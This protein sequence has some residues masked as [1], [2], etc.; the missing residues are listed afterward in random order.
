MTFLF[1]RG[2]VTKSVSTTMVSIS[3][4]ALLLVLPP[5][6]AAQD[7]DELAKQ[8]QNPVAEPD[9]RAAPGQLG[10]RPRRQRHHQHAAQLSAGRA[11]RGQLEHERHPARHHAAR[12]RSRGDRGL[13][14][15]GMGDI[16]ATAF[17]S[18]IE[19][20]RII[21]GVGPVVL[22]PT[23]TDNA[24][25]TQ[26]FGMGPTVVV[27]TQP[28]KWTLGTAV[29]PDLVDERRQGP[30]GRQ[31]D[32]P[33]AVCQLQ[34]GKRARGGRQHGSVGQLERRRDVDRAAALQRQ[35]GHAARQAAGELHGGR[36]PDGGQPRRRRQLAV[37]PGGDIP[38]PA[39]TRD[40]KSRAGLQ[41]VPFH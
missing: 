40:R 20:G 18:P 41:A 22:L 6:A 29:Q 32:V 4:L 5:P 24:L 3:A 13:R 14:I 37:P 11:V 1:R 2:D 38:V 36:R 19:S 31:P 10:L 28:G 33:A 12:C 17:F 9:Q 30:Q 26:K 7:A 21:W 8:T 34:P 15:N 23:A 39:L 35:Q 16:V 25:G 27:L